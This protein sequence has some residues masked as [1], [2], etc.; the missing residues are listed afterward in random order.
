[1]EIRE[2]KKSDLIEIVPLYCACF[3]EPPWNEQFNPIEVTAEILEV[4]GWPG[5]FLYTAFEGGRVIGAAY[6]FNL[7]HKP[8]VRGLADPS[9]SAF[10]VSEIFV[11]PTARTKGTA[12]ALV[13]SL[14]RKAQSYGYRSMVVRTSVEQPIIRRLFEKR[15][16]TVIATQTVLSTKIVDGRA[17]DAPDERV[18]MAD[19][20]F[21]RAE[22]RCE[23]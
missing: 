12:T 6:G 13:D 15:G 21:K 20:D 14:L 2:F 19:R 11:S 4:A 17:V 1:M 22:I 16:W 10:Y 18:I 5:A 9:S 3:A 23:H 7:T 8:D